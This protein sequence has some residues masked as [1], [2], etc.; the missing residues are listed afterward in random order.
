VLGGL[1]ELHTDDESLVA[2]AA[3]VFDALY[4]SPQTAPGASGTSG[5][6]R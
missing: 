5:A 4:A 6:S 2:A 1:R 3:A